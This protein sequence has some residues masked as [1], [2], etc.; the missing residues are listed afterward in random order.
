MREW[1]CV[2]RP[3]RLDIS[4]E[5]DLISHALPATVLFSYV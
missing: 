1:I 4:E 2:V 5:D 3:Y